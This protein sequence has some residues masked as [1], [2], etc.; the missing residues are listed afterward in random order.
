VVEI[1]EPGA[2]LPQ[3]EAIPLEIVYEDA[4]LLVVNKPAGMVVH[5]APGHPGGT[6]V[7]ALLAYR[8]DIVHA[9]GDPAR[10]G[11]V[12]RLDRD[13]TGLIVIA[14]SREVQAA[15]QG[16]FKARLVVKHY[17]A[18][19]DGHLEPQRGV[20]DAA[21]GRNPAHRQRMAVCPEDGRPARTTYHVREYL[22]GASYVEAHP[23]TGRTHQL[24]VHFASVGHPVVGDR[25]Y[26]PRRQAIP[27]P[28]QLLHAWRLAFTHPITGV[29]LAFSADPPADLCAVLDAL[30]ASS[31]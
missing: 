10:P 7:N 5:P 24:R 2:T 21:I 15:L 4:H 8:P 30:R 22:P 12:H 13:T 25:V 17:L 18:L 6:L 27:A 20:I 1:A 23:L 16:L 14:A 11:I 28:R 9:D 29:A 31:E 26:G 3:P 19:L